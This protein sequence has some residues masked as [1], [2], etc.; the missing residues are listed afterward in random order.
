M[1]SR[2]ESLWTCPAL[3]PRVHCQHRRTVYPYSSLIIKRTEATPIRKPLPPTPVEA[4][5]FSKGQP[6]I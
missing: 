4:P 3:Q 5:A 1:D 2:I 6:E